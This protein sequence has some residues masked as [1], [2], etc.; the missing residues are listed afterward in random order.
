MGYPNK[1][2]SPLYSMVVLNLNRSLVFFF[3]SFFSTLNV[4]KTPVTGKTLP[5]VNLGCARR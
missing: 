3:K 4:A 1:S 2:S 5:S